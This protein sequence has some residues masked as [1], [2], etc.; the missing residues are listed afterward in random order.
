MCFGSRTFCWYVLEEGP[1]RAAFPMMVDRHDSLFNFGTTEPRS[2][3]RQLSAGALTLHISDGA[4]RRLCWHGV[5]VVR[6][7]ACPIRDANWA[8]CVSVLA[9]ESVARSPDG[10]EIRQ[11]RLVANARCASNWFSRHSADG[12]F[13]RRFGNFGVPRIHHQPCGVHAAASAAARRRNA[14]QRHPSGRVGHC[15]GISAPDFPAPGGGQHFWPLHHAVNGI[16]VDITFHGEIFEMEDQRNWS[17]ASFKTYCRPLSLPRPY[18][19]NAGETH[20]QEIAIRFQGTP[21][22]SPDAPASAGAVLEWR[23]GAGTVPRL[24]VTMEDGT[25]PDAGAQGLCRLLKPAILQLRVT[26]QTAAAVFESAKRVV[27]HQPG[28][29]RAGNRGAVHG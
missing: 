8:T 18:R 25:L 2:E 14:A 3:D 20:R 5:E 13:Q 24:A 26:P 17:D 27:C 21:A 11:V 16:D 9:E 19:L 6:G 22:K 29:D 23:D 4:V 1:T 10:F 15:L 12:A 7:I 28:R